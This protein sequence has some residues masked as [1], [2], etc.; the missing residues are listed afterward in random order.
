MGIDPNDVNGKDLWKEGAGLASSATAAESAQI[1]MAMNSKKEQKIP[2]SISKEA[3]LDKIKSNADG[4][5]GQGKSNAADTANAVIAFSQM[6]G[7]DSEIEKA[8]TWLAENQQHIF[9]VTACAKTLTALSEAGIDFTLD[10]RFCKAEQNLWTTL[11]D[12]AAEDNQVL[13]TALSSYQ[14]CYK[15]KDRFYDLSKVQNRPWFD[16]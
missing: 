5:F 15:N 16:S 13:Y 12:A 8:V 6:E 14:R 2:S 10:D 3:L 1:L 7:K 11:K 4:G 9:R